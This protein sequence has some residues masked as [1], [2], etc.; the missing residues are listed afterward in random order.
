MDE[1]KILYVS[2]FFAPEITAAAFRAY[3]HCEIWSQEADVDL[4]VYTGNPNYPKGELYGGYSNR[5]IET[6]EL[7]HYR[8]VR[9]KSI[10]KKNTTQVGR[11]IVTLSFFLIGIFNI[12]FNKK[13][14]GKKFDIILGTSG[15]IFAGI[16]AYIYSLIYKAD[17]VFEVRDITYLQMIATMSQDKS[18]GVRIMRGLE[19]F[20]CK[21]AKSVIVV[22]EGFKQILIQEGIRREKISVIYNGVNVKEYEKVIE[23][24]ASNQLVLTYAGTIGISQDIEELI[25]FYNKIDHENKSLNI[26]G[27]GAQKASVIEYIQKHEIQG[28]TVFDAMTGEAFD[29]MLNKTTFAVVKLKYSTCFKNTIPSKVF[30]LMNRGIPILYLGPKGETSYHIDTAEAGISL[31]TMD[32]KE[33][34]EL[35]KAYLADIDLLTLS[36]NGKVYLKE[37]FDRRQLATVYLEELYKVYW[38]KGRALRKEKAR[39]YNQASNK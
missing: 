18:M 37:N 5:I 24:E 22:T 38:N 32:N 11:L 36:K 8:V 1:L 13:E 30:D 6:K 7:D 33:N 16:L 9:S 27:E 19:L 14:I 21:K 15:P 25:D 20:L 39:E 34:V 31:T 17:F 10:I 2:Q 35:F 26:I 12:I 4:T 3:D 28:V 23:K 29:N